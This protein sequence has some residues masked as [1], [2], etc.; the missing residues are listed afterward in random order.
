MSCQ[1]P[2]YSLHTPYTKS[3]QNTPKKHLK[4]IYDT[5]KNCPYRIGLQNPLPRPCKPNVANG[6]KLEYSKQKS[7]VILEFYKGNYQ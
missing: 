4:G 2:E 3:S 6:F 1:I 5:I 7:F